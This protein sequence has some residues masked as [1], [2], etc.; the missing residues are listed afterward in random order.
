MDAFEFFAVMGFAKRLADEGVIALRKGTPAF[1]LT[2]LAS[3]EHYAKCIA[4]REGHG[5][6]LAGGLPRMIA[7]FGRDAVRNAPA[8]VKGM[9]PYV[10]PG[11]AL[12]W[13]LMGTMEL[14]Q[15]LDPRGPHVGASGSPT[16]FAKRP[17]EVFPQHLAR[18]GAPAEAL[19]RILPDGVKGQSLSVGRL[20]KYSHRW[21]SILGSLGVCARAQVNRFYSASRC[22]ALYAAATGFAADVETLGRSADRAW[23]LLRM[24]N[25]REGVTRREDSPPE[26]WFEGPGFKHYLTDEKI[27]REALEGMISEYYEEQGWDRETGVP[28]KERL[29]E[30]DLTECL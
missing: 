28:T 3:M 19:P 30:L 14:G 11:A 9:Q 4:H 22:A 24:I 20:L 25:L 15:V 17:L 29:R 7:S 12:P 27:S 8:V 5:E 6:V 16:Y 10:G 1:D 23:T 18:M 2:S 26:A 21:F 13:N